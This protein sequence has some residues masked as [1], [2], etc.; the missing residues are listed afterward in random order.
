MRSVIFSSLVLAALTV[1][2]ARTASAQSAPKADFAFGYAYLHDNDSDIGF[3]SGWMA[4]VAG[5]ATSWFAVVAEIGGSQ[6]TYSV[7]NRELKLGVTTFLFGPRFGVTSR[8]PVAPFGELLFGVAHGKVDIGAP[9]VNL[10][11]TGN[12]FAVQGGVGLDL[13][14][15]RNV[16]ARFEADSR[17]VESNGVSHKQWRLVAALVLRK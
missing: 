12:N 3:P 2:P 5:N 1:F 10:L 14:A 4:S 15:S 13:N 17:S 16:G 11:V 8:S 9:N 7:P 6:R